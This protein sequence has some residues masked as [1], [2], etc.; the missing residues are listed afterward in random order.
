MDT[1]IVGEGEDGDG[2]KHI[3]EDKAAHKGTDENTIEVLRLL[4]AVLSIHCSYQKTIYSGGGTDEGDTKR[5][6]ENTENANHGGVVTR[7]EHGDIDD[8]GIVQSTI[9]RTLS[10]GDCEI[11]HDED[12]ATKKNEITSNGDD[13]KRTRE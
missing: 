2:T 10:R 11:H 3:V 1:S 4:H 9:T 13:A 5:E 12:D 8:E 6:A 7:E